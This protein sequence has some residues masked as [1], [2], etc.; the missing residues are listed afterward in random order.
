MHGRGYSFVIKDK[1]KKARS[2]LPQRREEGVFRKRCHITAANLLVSMASSP[3]SIFVQGFGRFRKKYESNSLPA[4]QLPW[5]P[6]IVWWELLQWNARGQIKRKKVLCHIVWTYGSLNKQPRSGFW[7]PR[8]REAVR[9]S[10]FKTNKS[11]QKETGGGGPNV[12]IATTREAKRERGEGRGHRMWA[13]EVGIQK[14]MCLPT[15][16]EEA[17][18]TIHSIDHGSVAPTW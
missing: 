9:R 7:L 12:N 11:H 16:D 1:G 10:N 4:C 2:C 5:K 14:K 13:T 15:K 8:G 6:N 18:H 17:Q 3:Q